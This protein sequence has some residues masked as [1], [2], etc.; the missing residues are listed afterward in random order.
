MQHGRLGGGFPSNDCSGTNLGWD[1]DGS[2][3]GGG[4]RSY[5]GFNDNMRGPPS[6]VSDLDQLSRADEVDNWAMTK[7]SIPS[8]DS[9]R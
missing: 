9:D 2:W 8:V 6:R 7:K 3:G 5:G 1:E 4:R